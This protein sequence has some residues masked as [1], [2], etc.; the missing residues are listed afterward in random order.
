MGDGGLIAQFI[1]A[2]TGEVIAVTD[3]NWM[4]TVI[5]KAPLDKACEK[6]ANPVAGE[7]P[8]GFT[9]LEEP[10]NW[11]DAAFDTTAWA[12]AVVYSAEQVDPKDGFEQ[13][14]W[15]SSAQFIWGPDLETN[16][17]L[18]CKLTING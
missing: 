11:L 10:A 18:L 2:D 9:S 4:C 16:N 3:S 5:H 8:C 12:K 1:N 13:I 14:S 17:T 15:N 6:S 7:M